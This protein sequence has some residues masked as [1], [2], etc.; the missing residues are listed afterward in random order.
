MC[1]PS[2]AD[3]HANTED[4]ISSQVVLLVGAVQGQHKLVDLLLRVDWVCKVYRSVGV[5]GVQ[6][7]KVYRS[8]G[9]QGVR[10]NRGA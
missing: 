1:C 3:G 5:Q 7:F 6:V 8:V 9:V 2:L 4:G 10:F